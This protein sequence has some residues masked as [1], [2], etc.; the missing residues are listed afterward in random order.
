MLLLGSDSLI[1]DPIAKRNRVKQP[2]ER[3]NPI[4][5]RLEQ[6]R[7][8]SGR[9]KLKEK[10]A[11]KNRAI[12]NEKRKNRP[13]R[14]DFTTDIWSNE[15]STNLSYINKEWMTT[16]TI[17][18]TLTHLGLKKRKLPSSVGQK[19]SL[20]P[21][22][23]IPH[24]GLSYNPSFND[25][26]CL[27]RDIANKELALMK[28]EAHLDR[29]TT[30]MFQ[31]VSLE[32]RDQ[33]IMEELSEGLPSI[34]QNSKEETVSLNNEDSASL[35]KVCS[36]SL[37]KTKKQKRK[38][39]EQKELSKQLKERKIEKKKITDIYRLKHIKMSLDAS[40]KKKDMLQK[41]RAQKKVKKCFE[42][43]TLSKVKFIPLESDFKLGEELTGSLRNSEPSS[44]I[45]KDRFK[46]LQQRNILAP[47]NK[48]L[49]LNKARVKRFIK[50]DHKI[51]F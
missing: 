51:L 10:L 34:S 41:K 37:R 5:R 22:I 50:P 7:L 8:I 20:L 3:K 4:T 25:H 31:K 2:E 26:Q 15:P 48:V 44:N 45:L 24:P 28:E 12:A 11:L 16:D 42:P 32:Q 30:K 46:S 33:K 17:R 1:S 43:K 23:E 18:H 21:P 38:Q 19:P 29:V 27:L 36:Q 14:G 13:K 6:E 49:K 39:K 40:D 35:T 9:L 47:G